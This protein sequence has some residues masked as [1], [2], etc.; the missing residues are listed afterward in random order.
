MT[1]TKSRLGRRPI[2]PDRVRC[3]DGKG[4][5]FIPNRFLQEGFFAS[6]G[7]DELVLYFLLALAGNRSGLSFYHYDSLCSLMG[8]TIE[9]YVAARNRLIDKDLIA[10]DGSRFQVLL[11]PKQVPEATP[12]LRTV[13][14]FEQED[15]ATIRLLIEESMRGQRR[16]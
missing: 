15:G 16:G 9:R 14:E 4:F 1:G 6:L 13:D 3:I 2:Q 11:L 10:F 7:I 5:A 12:P 8:M